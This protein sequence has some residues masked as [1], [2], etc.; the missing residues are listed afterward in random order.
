MNF[1]EQELRK[2][3]DVGVDL[4]NVKFAGRACYG[5]LGGENRAKLQFVTTGI[6]DHYS[7]LAVD[8][9]NRTDGKVDSLF[10]HF[11]DIWGNRLT[12]NP[13][14]RDGIVPHIWTSGN[15][16]EWSVYKPTPRDFEQLAE[17]VNGYLSVFMECEAVHDKEQSREPQLDAAIEAKDAPAPTIPAETETTPSTRAINGEVACY[18]VVISISDEFLYFVG[19][20]N[21]VDKIGSEEHSSGSNTDDVFVDFRSEEYSET[22]KQ[23]IADYLNERHGE[24]KSFDEWSDELFNARTSPDSLIIVP[25][26]DIARLIESREAAKVYCDSILSEPQDRETTFI[27]RVDKN[28]ADYNKSL[29]SFGQRELIEMAAAIHAH[30]DAWSY[31][32]EYHA[33]TDEELDFFLR[34]ENPLEVVADQCRERNIDVGD[35]EFSIDF[36][37]EPERQTS[38]LKAYPLIADKPPVAEPAVEPTLKPAKQ[39][40]K[41]KPAQAKP[42]QPPVKPKPQEKLSILADLDASIIEAQERNAARTPHAHK[43]SNQ[44]ELD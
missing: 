39:P 3:I 14:F 43:K 33:Y 4:D 34:F 22:R 29:L 13:N 10:F 18:D 12:S 2:L 19:E 15:K 11:K 27:T 36:V 42:A 23:E 24:S 28:Y 32:T 40:E 26:R 25:E 44:K 5:D 30:S 35:V 38:T 21:A 8:I 16:N 9:L 37:M 17:A 6:A 41:P 1:F 7:T 31:M 20:V